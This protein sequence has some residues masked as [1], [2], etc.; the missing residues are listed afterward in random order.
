MATLT[1]VAVAAALLVAPGPARAASSEESRVFALSNA[2][3]ASAGVAPLVL[4]ESLSAVSRR[5]VTTMAASGTIAHNPD[6]ATQVTGW[7]KV[8]ENV[9]MG[10]DLETIHRAL[11]ASPRHYANLVD[12]DV[13]LMGVA[14]VSSGGNVFVVE[15]F[16]RPTG[17]VAP[18][19]VAPPAAAQTTTRPAAPPS[20]VARATVVTT[21]VPLRPAAVAPSTTVP[22]SP[23]G[24]SPWL[25]FAIEMTRTW[26]RA[27]G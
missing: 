8:S 4:D 6:L 22:A 18:R 3:R 7:S 21:T 9:G 27:T 26:E 24:P 23:V 12:P 10:P 25:T 20:T 19:T 11:V 1:G 16:M 5:W 15:N 13:T 14:V 2:V 17:S